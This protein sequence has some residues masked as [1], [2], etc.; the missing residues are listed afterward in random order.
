MRTLGRTCRTPYQCHLQN[1]CHASTR[2]LLPVS[3]VSAV[4]RSGGLKVR[5]LRYSPMGNTLLAVCEVAELGDFVERMKKAKN[6][7]T[8]FSAALDMEKLGVTLHVEVVYI[9]E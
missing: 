7:S 2:F 3:A 4:R 8:T 9:D 5:L 1:G 6:S